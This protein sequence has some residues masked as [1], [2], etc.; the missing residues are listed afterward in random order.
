MSLLWAWDGIAQEQVGE[1]QYS[2]RLVPI[3]GFCAMEGEDEDSDDDNAFGK[4]PAW[5]RG[6]ILAAGSLMNV[7]LTIV[8]LSVLLFSAG[9]PTN[10]IGKYLIVPQLRRHHPG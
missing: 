10:E 3:G 8:I 9:Y 2:L 4:K 1:T 6:I 5:Q 7:A